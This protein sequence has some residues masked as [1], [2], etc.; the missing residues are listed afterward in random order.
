M[1]HFTV[2]NVM[3]LL[4]LAASALAVLNGLKTYRKVEPGKEPV[5]REEYDRDQVLRKE[6]GHEYKAELAKLESRQERLENHTDQ[7]FGE[8]MSELTDLRVELGRA[9]GLLE[10]LV[11][12]KHG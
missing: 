8:L 1:E 3:A 4:A 11:K 12:E 7:R 10:H 6:Q 5:T 2:G 9:V